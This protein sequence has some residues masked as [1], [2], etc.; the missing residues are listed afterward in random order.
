MRITIEI[1]G[2]KFDVNSNPFS[3]QIQR[4]NQ[5]Y[6]R[7]KIERVFMTDLDEVIT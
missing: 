3:G 5:L 1:L 2:K 4:M 6:F 7:R